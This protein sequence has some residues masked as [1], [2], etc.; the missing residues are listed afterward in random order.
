MSWGCITADKTCAIEFAYI[1]HDLILRDVI[2][3]WSLT[4]IYMKQICQN[5]NEILLNIAIDSSQ[6]VSI[7]L[8][9]DW[10]EQDQLKNV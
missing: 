2:K 1:G 7:Q 5:I 10:L 3:L 9:D 6:Y 8:T 4:P